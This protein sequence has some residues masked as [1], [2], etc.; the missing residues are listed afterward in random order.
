MRKRERVF[1]IT[2]K[3]IFLIAS[4]LMTVA[5]YAQ[6]ADWR[7]RID[8]KVQWA[9]SLSLKSQK[10]FYLNKF[11]KQ[12]KPVKETWYYTMQ[13]GK[14]LIFEINYVSD[15]TEFSEIYYLDNGRLICM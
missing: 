4:L 13:D 2:Q 8:E 10:V 5:L 3:L 1:V 7:T 14:I 15:A 11:L 9:D 12:D 6:R